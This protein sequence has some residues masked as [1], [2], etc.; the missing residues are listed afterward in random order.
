MSEDKI[1]IKKQVEIK[2][3]LDKYKI[4][5]SDLISNELYNSIVKPLVSTLSTIK[6]DAEIVLSG[7]W[8]HRTVDGIADDFNTQIELIDQALNVET[9]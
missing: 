2:I 6:Q 8:D 7:N 4:T 9:N 5:N 1:R 3:I